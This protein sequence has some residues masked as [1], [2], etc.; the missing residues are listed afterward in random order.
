MAV[1]GIDGGD[2]FDGSCHCQHSIKNL[3]KSATFPVLLV[4]KE[5]RILTIMRIILVVM[6][7]VKTCLAVDFT[8]LKKTSLKGF[9]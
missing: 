7:N 2:G 3:H 1:M 5:M 6:A 8:Q 4:Q 9:M